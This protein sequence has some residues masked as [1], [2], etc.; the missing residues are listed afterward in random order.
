[1]I[2]SP[3]VNWENL[4]AI[5]G[6]FLERLTFK[7]FLYCYQRIARWLKF[8]VVFEEFS[9]F[10]QGIS[11]LL[12]R[13]RLYPPKNPQIATK[14]CFRERNFRIASKELSRFPENSII[15]CIKF[16]NICSILLNVYCTGA[17]LA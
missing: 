2:V 14:N 6:C 1:M 12:L 4:L 15:A 8:R 17:V 5:F 7:G 13:I 3:F 10:C 11:S 16:L 9:I